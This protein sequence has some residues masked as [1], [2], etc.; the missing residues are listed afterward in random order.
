MKEERVQA[1]WIIRFKEEV[2]RSINIRF[3]FHESKWNTI[4]NIKAFVY[5]DLRVWKF[6]NTIYYK[7]Y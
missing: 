7:K 1:K 6:L 4:S 5:V 3:G 2:G